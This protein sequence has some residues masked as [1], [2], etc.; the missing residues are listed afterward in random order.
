MLRGPNH[1]FERVNNRY[2][3]L[4]GGR[5]VVGRTVREALPEIE[6]QGYFELLDQVYRS[7]KPHVAVD[8]RVKL[9][10]PSNPTERVL[11]FVYQPMIDAD[12]TVSGVIV[13]GIDMT[14]QRQAEAGIARIMAKS[15]RQRRMY[16]T[17][18]SNTADFV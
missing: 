7:G 6:G 1:V 12:G 9:R 17:A 15:E 3:E 8:A 10:N 2:V 4:I 14:E 13:Q 16:E 18:L 5:D 11:Q